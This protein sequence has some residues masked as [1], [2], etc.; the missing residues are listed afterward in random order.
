MVEASFDVEATEYNNTLL[1]EENRGF[2]LPV[3]VPSDED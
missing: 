1:P 3:V 2:I